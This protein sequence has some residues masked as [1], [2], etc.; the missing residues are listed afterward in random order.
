MVGLSSLEAAYLVVWLNMSQNQILHVGLTCI[1]FARVV[2]KRC[3]GP[4]RGWVV[5]GST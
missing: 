1:S 3:N 4:N 5:V 2:V